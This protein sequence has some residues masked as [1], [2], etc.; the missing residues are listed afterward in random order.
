MEQKVNLSFAAIQPYVEDNIIKNV[1]K[2]VKGKDMVEYGE[3]NI[4]PNYLYALYQGVSVLHS[5]IGGCADYASGENIALG[6]PLLSKKVNPNET[7]EDVCHQMFIDLG[8]YGGFALNVVRNKKGEIVALYNLDFKNI[9]SDKHNT[10]FY[11]SDKWAEKSAGRIDSQ[12]YPAFDPE[13]D[14]ANSIY[15]Y[16]NDKHA[17]YPTPVWGGATTAAECL[18]HVGEFHL[19]SLYNGL[20]SDYI[21]NFNSG[22]PSDEQREEIEA[23]FEEKYSGY[24]NGSRTMLSFQNDFAHRTTVEAIP[25][26]N[27]LDKYNTLTQDSKKDL[28]TAFRVHPALF[29]LPTENSGFNTQDINEAFKVAN[30]TVI[31]PMQKVVK[32][33][34]ETIFKTP[35]VLQIDPIEID[36]SDKAKN[37]NVQ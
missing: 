21:V 17:T 2:E 15:Y 36:W 20:S 3:K 14:D 6:V 25:Q 12:V 32:R 33:A 26:T 35:E 7:V 30:K 19:N 22:S 24:Q 34:F 5:I 23:M 4:Y 29:G 27:F 10:K 28:F 9:R 18:K 16:K 31:L 13:K 8:V 11:Y 1:Q 37:T